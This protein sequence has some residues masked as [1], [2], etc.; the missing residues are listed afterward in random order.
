MKGSSIIL[1]AV[2]SLVVALAATP[3][4]AQSA[5]PGKE[6][7]AYKIVK[8]YSDGDAFWDHGTFDDVSKRLYLGRENGITTIDTQTGKLTDRLLEGKQ[9]HR[10]VLLPGGRAIATE[11]GGADAIVFER[12]TGKVLKRIPTGKK[13]DAATLDSTT[14]TVVI[15]D[16]ISRDAV[17]VDAT[18]LKV[19]GRLKFDGEPETPVPDGKG[20]VFSPI[21]DKSKI[22][23]I[24]VKTR[25]ILKTY[26][27][28]DCTDASGLDLDPLTGVLL[29]ACANQKALTLKAETG[30]ILGSTAIDK[31][32]DG[33]VFDRVRDVF[34]VPCF[35]PGTLDV[36]AEGKN[37]APVQALS[38]PIA[39]GVHTEG[40]D[41]ETGKLYL[42]A[43]QIILP[44]AKGGR[45]SVAHGTFK[46]FV[47][48]VN[49]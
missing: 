22:N 32:P 43:G 34:Y 10:I 20:H 2:L 31:Y 7:H 35:V 30:E 42:P 37:G 1:S 15:M 6:R 24:D 27:L 18:S 47:V 46:I 25:K 29:V 49:G 13:P 8:I 23:L 14:N 45:P 5:E 48:D 26:A 44:K 17:F 41:A 36:L 38:M 11:G 4:I 16:G 39:P 21:A 9:V 3:A 40:L 28:P 19:L 12:D 33:I